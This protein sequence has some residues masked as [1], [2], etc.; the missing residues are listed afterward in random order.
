MWQK[1]VILLPICM[2]KVA[3]YA[4]QV[5]EVCILLLKTI[6]SYENHYHQWTKPK[7]TW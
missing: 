3:K 1:D 4:P 7:P 2:K 6:P 5:S